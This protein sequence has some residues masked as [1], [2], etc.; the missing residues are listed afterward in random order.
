MQQ[1]VDAAGHKVPGMYRSA[2]GALIVS[3]TT[4]YNRALSDKERII[5]MQSKIDALG[6][7]VQQLKELLLTVINKHN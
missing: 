4:A 2:D 6:N 1:V 5:K 7:D 3:D